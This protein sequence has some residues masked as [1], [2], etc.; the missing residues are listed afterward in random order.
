MGGDEVTPTWGIDVTGGYNPEGN[1]TS[2]GLPPGLMIHG[3]GIA[4]YDPEGN[5]N[6][7]RGGQIPGFK[8]SRV[9]GGM[10]TPEGG[11]PMGPAALVAAGSRA[12]RTSLNLQSV[13]AHLRNVLIVCTS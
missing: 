13:F 1:Y 8:N 12:S 10:P 6:S 5:Y 9:T 11:G 2:R 4:S 7:T 3:P